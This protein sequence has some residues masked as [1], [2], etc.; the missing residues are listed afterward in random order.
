MQLSLGSCLDLVS[1]IVVVVF[2]ISHFRY[3]WMHCYKIWSWMYTDMSSCFVSQLN[4]GSSGWMEQVCIPLWNHWKQTCIKWVS[5]IWDQRQTSI[6]L[7]WLSCM[8]VSSLCQ[9]SPQQFSLLSV[10]AIKYG[11]I[12]EWLFTLSFICC[13]VWYMITYYFL[14]Q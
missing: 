3:N 14:L 4:C 6:I 1:F 13:W 8:L 7:L 10:R 5:I 9:Y 2:G 12:S 11:D